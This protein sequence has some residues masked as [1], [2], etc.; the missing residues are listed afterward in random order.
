MGFKIAESHL[1]TGSHADRVMDAIGWMGMPSLWILGNLYKRGGM[2]PVG[3]KRR[4]SSAMIPLPFTLLSHTEGTFVVF[5]LAS[6]C[7]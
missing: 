2:A 4:C 3:S 6:V 5:S 1:E 7:F